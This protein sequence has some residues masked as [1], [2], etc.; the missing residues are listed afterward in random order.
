VAQAKGVLPRGEDKDVLYKNPETCGYFVSVKLDPAIDRGRAQAWFAEVGKLVGELVERLPAKRGQTKG[1]KVAA[2][3]VGLAPSFFIVNGQPRFDPPLEPPAAFAIEAAD[4]MPSSGT[5]LAGIAG[6]EGDILFYVAS[7]FEARV[8]AF[9][10]ALA[11]MKPNVA[12]VTFDRGYQRIDDTEPFGYADGLRNIRREDRPEFVF[13]DHEERHLEEPAWAHGGT[14]M[15]FLKIQQHPDA[16]AALPDEQTR[17]AIIGRMK[18]GDRLDLA[19]QNIDPKK[20]PSEPPPNLPPASHVM[21]VGPRGKHDDTQIFRRGLPFIETSPDGQPHIGLNFCSFQASLDQFDV[22]F[23]DWAMNGR[24][25]IDTAGPDAL[26]DGGRQPQPLTTIEKVGFFFVPPYREE[27]LAAAVF[28][29]A[30]KPQKPKHGRLVVRK[31]VRSNADQTQRFERG[32]FVFQVLNAQNQPVGGQFTS[33]STGR[34]I[35]PEKLEIGQSY[36]LEEVSSPFGDRVQLQ[37]VSFTMEKSRQPITLRNLVSP[38]GPYGA[39]A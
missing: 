22:V 25:P 20:E 31:S 17:D 13:V 14:Y 34:A 26:L 32:G 27:S 21:K 35:C 38:T 10:S 15:A 2:V 29:A 37:T 7:V 12:S 23:N 18:E 19:G 36:V 3:A 4:L 6:V 39:A 30:A 28:P 11:A 5:A 8:N 33:D 1:D 16:F 24:F 9:I